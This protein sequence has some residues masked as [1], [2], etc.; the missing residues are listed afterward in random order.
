MIKCSRCM[1]LKDCSGSDLTVTCGYYDVTAPPWSKYAD[2]GE[3]A[4]CDECMHADPRYL[5][6]YPR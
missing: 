5:K 4:V 2:P 3:K 6:D 1:K